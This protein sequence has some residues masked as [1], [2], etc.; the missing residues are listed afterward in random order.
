MLLPD[1]TTG[2]PVTLGLDA[3]A[4]ALDVLPVAVCPPADSAIKV[5]Q[6]PAAA[7]QTIRVFMLTSKKLRAVRQVRRDDTRLPLV[8]IAV[9]Y[10]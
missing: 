5:R 3:V 10:R 7:E 1:V 6:A 9:A 2:L 8:T 4:V